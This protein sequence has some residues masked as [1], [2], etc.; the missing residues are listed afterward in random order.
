M[1]MTNCRYLLY[2]LFIP[3]PLQVKYTHVHTVI[4]T[5]RV[6]TVQ[7]STVEYSTDCTQ[8]IEKISARFR[9][10]FS[11]T[12]DKLNQIRSCP[13]YNRH[14]YSLAAIYLC[15]FITNSKGKDQPGKVANP[16]CG[17]LNRD[18]AFFPVPV[19]A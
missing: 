13:R 18:N 8:R 14:F 7:N 3:T 1:V 5:T 15:L 19:R 6:S 9:F 16:T 17:Q 11:S 12:H 4:T 2:S 10:I